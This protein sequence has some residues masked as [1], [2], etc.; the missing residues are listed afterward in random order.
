MTRRRRRQ[1]FYLLVALFFIIGT[2]I[3]LYAQGWRLNVETWHAS[4]VGGIFI[5]SFPD[6]AQIVLDKKPVKNESAFLSRGTL[7]SDLFPKTYWIELKEAGYGPW[8]ESA[9]VSPSLVAEFKYAVLV[10]QNATTA[11]EGLVQNFS[12]ARGILATQNWNGSV[13]SGKTLIGKGALIDES[14]D[15]NAV[16]IKNQ[17][18]GRYMLYQFQNGS[19]TD[20]TAM[21]AKTGAGKSDVSNIFF[22]PHDPGTIIAAGLSKIWLIDI[23]A[24][25]TVQIEKAPAGETH[26]D[27]IAAG[28]SL[29]AWTESKKSDVS[30]T[31]V[32]YDKS[33]AGIVASSTIPGKNRELKWVKDNFLGVLQNDG[34]LYLYGTGA[35]SIKKIADDVE[36]FA[37]TG[38]GSS[39]AALENRSME[40]IPFADVSDGY[41]RFNLPDIANARR[42]TWY[43]DGMHLFVEYGDHVSLLDLKDAGLNNFTTVA[44]GTAP[45]YD[46]DKNALYLINPAENLVRFDF[47]E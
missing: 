42:V 23:A 44:I 18:D 17:A 10:P 22:D 20:I 19:T 1:I 26:G 45:F 2:A 13:V 4:K 5:R 28:S 27:V 24:I 7:I 36:Y 38:N 29:I 32:I 31:I 11:A 3:V 41:Y 37:A 33:S 40:I 21:L 9:T 14:S 39:I 35:Q 43:K 46:A 6:D 47:P 15:G 30:S 12:I 8:R 16:I 34:E 25:K